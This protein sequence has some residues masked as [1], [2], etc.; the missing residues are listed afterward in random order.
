MKY[1]DPS[2]INAALSMEA[3]AEPLTAEELAILKSE[4]TGDPKGRG[5]KDKKPE[6]LVWLLGNEYTEENKEKQG[7]LEY[8][9]IDATDVMNMFKQIPMR[10]GK[11]GQVTAWRMLNKLAESGDENAWE[12]VDT[13]GRFSASGKP[14]RVQNPSIQ[15]VIPSLIASGLLTAETV[16]ALT[17]Y[18]DPNYKPVTE[19]KRRLWEL[20]GE[21]AVVSKADIEKAVA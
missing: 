19:P 2:L 10:D 8:E 13:I 9:Y 11:G 3:H 1:I 21:G 4:L 18:P 20:F 17:T 7:R 16:E 5:Y 14:L 12:A 15:A 6:E